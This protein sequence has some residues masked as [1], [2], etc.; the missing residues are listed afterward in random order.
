VS[1]ILL[2]TLVDHKAKDKQPCVGLAAQL[3]TS[4]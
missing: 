2:Q 4:T 3:A 1:S